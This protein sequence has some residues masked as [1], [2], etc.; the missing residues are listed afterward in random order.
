MHAERNKLEA[1][2]DDSCGALYGR[3]V[4]MD[5]SWT[6]YNVFTGISAEAG[7]GAM[8]SLS[9]ADATDKMALLNRRPHVQCVAR[10]SPGAS[11]PPA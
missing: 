5:R 2:K 9:R 11:L 4:E 1:R 10:F 3:R 8:S 6:V 7:L